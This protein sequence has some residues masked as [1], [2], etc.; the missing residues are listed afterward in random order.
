MG[1]ENVPGPVLGTGGAESTRLRPWVEEA[2]L[3][4]KGGGS[5][6][7]RPHHRETPGTWRRGWI[8]LPHT[9]LGLE[10]GAGT[11]L[12]ALQGLVPELAL[13]PEEPVL[14]LTR[15]HTHHACRRACHL[16]SGHMYTPTPALMTS[17]DT[18]DLTHSRTPPQPVNPGCRSSQG[19]RRAPAV[20]NLLH[21]LKGAHGFQKPSL[22]KTF[23]TLQTN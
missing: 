7:S 17:H 1:S 23:I 20:Q 22:P 19:A 8:P 6:S 3:S 2:K 14:L 15:S 12:P 5:P 16:C 18:P 11:L 10:A 13:L 9:C 21:C 4:S